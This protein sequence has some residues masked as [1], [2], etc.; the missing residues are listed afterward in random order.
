M[1][2]NEFDAPPESI[3]VSA[4]FCPA[5][6]CGFAILLAMLDSIMRDL[7]TSIGF[8]ASPEVGVNVDEASSLILWLSDERDGVEVATLSFFVMGAVSTFAL[9]TAVDA[10]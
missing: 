9:S 7:L 3:A 8:D 2:A 5:S 1:D 10:V 6:D 4:F